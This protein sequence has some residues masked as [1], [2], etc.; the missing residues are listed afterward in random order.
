MAVTRIPIPKWA[1]TPETDERLE[2]SL[3]EVDLAV[4]TVNCLEDRGIFTIEDLLKCTAEELL[5]IPNFGAKTLDTVYD[6]LEEI[7]FGRATA[8]PTEQ[9]DL[10]VVSAPGDFALLSEL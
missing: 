8:R 6:A 3:A 10:Q 2:R 9:P 1:A 7:G 5:E 4:R